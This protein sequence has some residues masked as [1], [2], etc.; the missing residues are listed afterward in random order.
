[1]VCVVLKE[2][3]E[4]TEQLKKELKSFVEEQIAKIVRPDEV[5][6]VKDLP[7]TRTGKIVRRMVRA[8]LLGMDPGDLTTLENPD[9]LEALGRLPQN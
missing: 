6:F 7:K 3:H 9:S 1:V 5:K 8:K 2:N 4:P